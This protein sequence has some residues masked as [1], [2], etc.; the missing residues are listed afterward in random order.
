MQLYAQRK[1]TKG[2]E[3]VFQSTE[4][5]TVLAITN[6]LDGSR[7]RDTLL[8]N[9]ESFGP[10]VVPGLLPLTNGLWAA[11]NGFVLFPI[12]GPI[13]VIP[14]GKKMV[15]Y[16]ATFH[17]KTEPAGTN[18]TKVIVRTVES[19]VINGKEPTLLFGW[20]QHEEHVAP[21][22]QEETNVLLVISNA[23]SVLKAGT[24]NSAAAAP[25]NGSVALHVRNP[26]ME[27]ALQAVLREAQA[28]RNKTNPPR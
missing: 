25:T 16:Y 1:I 22:L 15:S 13:A 24:I 8:V 6:A 2:T 19:H 21:V 18:L 23:L 3:Q 20:V 12:T 28:L 26:E 4:A 17:I 14:L 5:E 9:A 11:T 10:G 27:S 7:Y